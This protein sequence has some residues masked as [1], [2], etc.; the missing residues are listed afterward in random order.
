MPKKFY[1]YTK[2]KN[3]SSTYIVYAQGTYNFL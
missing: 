2:Q 1:F 3:I